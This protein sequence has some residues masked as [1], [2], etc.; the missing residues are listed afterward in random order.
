MGIF[1]IKKS[2]SQPGWRR[3]VLGVFERG[4]CIRGGQILKMVSKEMWKNRCVLVGLGKS[5]EYVPGSVF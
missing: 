1:Q 5:E 2:H 3:K 4:Q